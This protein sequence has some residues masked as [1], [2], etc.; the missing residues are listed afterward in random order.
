V[1]AGPPPTDV[2]ATPRS[3]GDASGSAAAA[4]RAEAR[5]ASRR[6]VLLGATTVLVLL[7]AWVTATSLDLVRDVALPTPASVV[8]AA[9]RTET[10]GYRGHAL[11]E[12]L[13]I[14]LGRVLLAFAIALLSAV[15]LGI[16]AG[17]SPSFEAL[18][19]PVVNFLRVLPPL[20]YLFLLI[21]WLG[22][23]ETSKVT[24]LLLA[25]FPPIF[26]AVAQGVRRIP[27]TR[28]DA[29]SMLGA[30]GWRYLRHAVLPSVLPDLFTGARV[31]IGFTYTTVVAAEI[32]A[33]DSGIGWMTLT[34]YKFLQTDVVWVGMLVMG[35]TGMALDAVVRALHR[36]YVPW[37][38]RA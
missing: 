33:A 10:E 24:L 7:A 16:L 31:A 8:E 11:H 36:H 32:V 20:A 29:A 21:I 4:E 18:L 17:V 37:Q 19:D 9:V 6:R 15:P 25:A 34:A 22:I 26:I 30:R 23:G 14:S 13:L 1:S 38:G 5:A 12:H 2:V 27:Q 28:L 3:A 35:F